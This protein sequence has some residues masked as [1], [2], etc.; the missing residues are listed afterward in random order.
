MTAPDGQTWG[1]WKYDKSRL[2]LELDRPDRYGGRDWYEVDLERCDS[3]AAILDWVLQ[4]AA[5]AWASE[6]D[7]GYLIR[8]LE[9]TVGPGLQGLV[10]PGGVNEEISDMRAHL[11]GP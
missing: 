10:C 11:M 5:K 9:S 8:A 4:V 3:G 2:V 1:D 7:I 6:E